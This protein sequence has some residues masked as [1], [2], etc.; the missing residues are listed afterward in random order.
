MGKKAQDLNSTHYARASHGT[1]YEHFNT[2]WYTDMETYQQI[3]KKKKHVY[4]KTNLEGY[5]RGN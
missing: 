1:Q 5:D 2:F 3:K 4:Y